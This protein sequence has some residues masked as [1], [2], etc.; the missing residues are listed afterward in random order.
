MPSHIR[1]H[2]AS[3]GCG[4]AGGL[5]K[6]LAELVTSGSAEVDVQPYRPWRFGGP[7]ASTPRGFSDHFAVTVRLEVEGR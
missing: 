7:N 6:A 4:G 1:T 5:G 3:G 2:R